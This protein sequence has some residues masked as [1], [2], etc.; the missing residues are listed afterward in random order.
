M[1]EKKIIV[2]FSALCPCAVRTRLFLLIKLM[3]SS[4]SHFPPMHYEPILSSSAR[5]DLRCTTA[6]CMTSLGQQFNCRWYCNL[7][8]VLLWLN[9]IPA[10]FPLK[11]LCIQITPPLILPHFLIGLIITARTNKEAFPRDIRVHT[12]RQIDR[13]N[14]LYILLYR[15]KLVSVAICMKP[16]VN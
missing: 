15:T 7:Y 16:Y 12:G 1:R 2:G 9:Y 8:E 5:L 6:N 14:V 11:S 10:N 4:I 13:V 3:T